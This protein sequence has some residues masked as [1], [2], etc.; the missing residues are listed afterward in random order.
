[1]FYGLDRTSNFLNPSADGSFFREG[2]VSQ[3]GADCFSP[4][5]FFNE[6]IDDLC[7]VM[8]FGQEKRREEGEGFVMGFAVEPLDFDHGESFSV[9]SP[10]LSCSRPPPDKFAGF[11]IF[12]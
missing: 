4:D 5:I 9:Q 6:G 3:D 11:A 1:M 10:G 2:E 12:A 7:G 8:D